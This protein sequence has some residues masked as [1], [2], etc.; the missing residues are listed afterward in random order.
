MYNYLCFKCL[1]EI[2]YRSFLSITRPSLAVSGRAK[3]ITIIKTAT[4]ARSSLVVT[5]DFKSEY[6]LIVTFT[7]IYSSVKSLKQSNLNQKLQIYVRSWDS[8][9]LLFIDH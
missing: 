3:D 4:V 6:R 5:E 9:K 2:V 1:S 8:N 7:S